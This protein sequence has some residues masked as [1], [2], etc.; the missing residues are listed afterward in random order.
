MSCAVHSAAMNLRNRKVRNRA[1]APVLVAA[2]VSIAHA[3]AIK[4]YQNRQ[5]LNGSK[6][7]L[8]Q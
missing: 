1:V 2:M 8:I 5:Q 3:V 7:F 6:L 4:I